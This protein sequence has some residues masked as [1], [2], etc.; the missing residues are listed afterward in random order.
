M[1]RFIS[2]VA[3]TAAVLGA[4]V[5]FESHHGLPMDGLI[6][7]LARRAMLRAVPAGQGNAGG[8]NYAVASKASPQTLTIRHDGQV[9]FRHLANTGIPVSPTADDAY[10]A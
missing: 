3:L 10:P 6:G 8:Y 2:L 1:A 9:V 7:P 4:G 5:A